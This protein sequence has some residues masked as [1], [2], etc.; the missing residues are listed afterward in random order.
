MKNLTLYLILAC[1]SLL[2]C[3]QHGKAQSE[4]T[5]TQLHKNFDELYL[6]E[7]GL[8]F[9]HDASRLKNCVK[10]NDIKCMDVYNRVQSVKKFL[11]QHKSNFLLKDTLNIIQVQCAENTDSAKIKCHGALMSLYIYS[12][13]EDDQL[14]FLTIS[15]LS[16]SIQS[17][18]FNRPHFW[19]SNRP[20][21]DL[22]IEY[23]NKANINWSQPE[24]KTYVIEKFLTW[25]ERPF[26]A[27]DADLNN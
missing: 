15:R 17:V 23:L 12:D 25:N 6:G 27:V 2:L 4:Y 20:K 18:I 26:W 11:M 21:P 22:W 7:F 8:D 5:L 14:L 16:P 24:L 19:F 1:C 13:A 9:P 3:C 10:Y